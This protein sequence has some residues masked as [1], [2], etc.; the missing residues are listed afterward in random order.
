[1]KTTLEYI[2]LKVESLFKVSCL[3]PRRIVAVVLIVAAGW[4]LSACTG[5]ARIVGDNS[6]QTEVRQESPAAIKQEQGESKDAVD[7]DTAEVPERDLRRV[8][9]QGAVEVV[10]SPTSTLAEAGALLFFEVSM[11]THSVDLSMD[12]AG[13]STLEI[14]DGVR[15]PAVYWSGGS[16]HHVAGQLGFPN[17]F[18]ESAAA[19]DGIGQLTLTIRGVDADERVFTW[20][21][22]EI[23]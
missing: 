5:S 17:Q 7:N 14:G 18:S 8:D 21:I 23:Q 15:I 2:H 9:S 22:T 1:M 19:V 6:S 10:I 3:T 4:L 13:L 12:L 16:G 20:Q 11:N